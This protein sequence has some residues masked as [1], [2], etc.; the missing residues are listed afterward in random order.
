MSLIDRDLIMRQLRFLQQL[1]A[2]A[3]KAEA[4]NDFITALDVLRGGYREALGLPQELISRVDMSSALLMLR[5]K[6][7][8]R[9]YVELLRAEAQVLTAQG[10]TAAADA[11]TRR[12]TGLEAALSR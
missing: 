12:A 8:Q 6:E 3:K 10:D 1:L 2:R 5:T 11:A 4:E 7:R 9:A